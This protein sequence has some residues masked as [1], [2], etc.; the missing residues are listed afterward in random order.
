MRNRR[1]NSSIPIKNE[2][3]RL[4]LKALNPCR[5]GERCTVFMENSLMTNLQRGAE[6]EDLLAGLSYSI[7]QNYI[8]RVVGKRP[9]GRKIFFQGGVAFNKS[10]VAAFE[11]YLDREITVP[12]NHDVTGAIGMALIAMKHMNSGRGGVTPPLQES[13]TKFKGFGLSKRHYEISSFECKGCPNVCEINRVKVEGER[14]HLFYG[15]RC[16]KYDVRKG[17]KEN[18]PPDLFALRDELLWRAH[19]NRQADMSE[20]ASPLPQSQKSTHSRPKIGIPYVFYFHDYLPFWTTLLWELGFEVEV[21]GKTDRNIV[22]LGLESVLSETCFPIKTAHGHIKYLLD[23]GVETIFIPSFVNLNSP[24]DAF[25]RGFACPYTQTIPYSARVAFKGAEFLTPVVDMSR[26]AAYLKKELQ[27]VF[28]PFK[29]S[30]SRVSKGLAAARAAQEEFLMQIRNEG[31]KILS[32]LKERAVVI[33]GRAYNSFDT[34]M[35]LN[36]PRKLADLGV[37]SIPMDFLPIEPFPISIRIGPICIGGP[38]RGYWRCQNR[39]GQPPS[40]CGLYR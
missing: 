27:R 8:N 22:D 16:E 11:K 3:E 15:G 13:G 33:T 40:S 14:G 38:A 18:A 39:Q 34:G 24:G 5:L 29:I 9:I 23:R 26:G 19:L 17:R 7:V 30:S 2:F 6:R 10:V 31:E 20:M 1:K 36:I 32:S 21:S 25:E 28:K 4:A 12:P 37:L 35:N